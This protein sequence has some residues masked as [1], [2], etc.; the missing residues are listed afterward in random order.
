[1]LLSLALLS[2]AVSA[3]T[4]YD[5]RTV[6]PGVP[7]VVSSPT[8]PPV[9]SPVPSPTDYDSI[10]GITNITSPVAPAPDP[11]PTPAPTPVA[12]KSYVIKKGDTLCEIAA[13][14][15]GDPR[16]YAE[17]VEANAVRYPA[18]RKNPNLI[19]VGWELLLPGTGGETRPTTPTTSTPSN[20]SG[21]Q[22]TETRASTPTPTSADALPTPTTPV[23]SAAPRPVTPA[24]TT[25]PTATTEDNR[26][27]ITENSRVLHIG[28][29]HTVG[30]YGTEVDSLMRKTGAKV[31]TYGVA[32]S[33][34]SWWW[35]GTTTKCG[36]V[37][38]DDK[39]KVDQPPDWRTPRTTPNF[40]GLVQEFQPS[41]VVIS[42]GANMTGN[43]AAKIEADVQKMLDLAK[44]SG[45]Q[46]VWVGPPRGR[47]TPQREAQK[48]Q[49]CSII[50]RLVKQ[51]GGTF[52]DSRPITKYPDS[53]GDGLHY[54]GNEGSKTAKT[55]ANQVLNTIQ[56]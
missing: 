46:I 53:G 6:D 39:G 21:A 50:S 23:V 14:L 35:N 29:S 47:D 33:S 24:P 10:P 49:V 8:Q 32:G 37:G 34:P 42:L 7:L 16:R 45:A 17:I 52:I 3:Q 31:Q 41:V 15:L 43:S 38:R 13:R 28:D 56:K 2:P 9:P 4:P 54:W 22:P 11:S 30:I 27:M 51:S 5:E 55:W 36:Y 25:T 19:L 48:E 26:P 12:P 20:S 40:S 44:A 1:M 18:L